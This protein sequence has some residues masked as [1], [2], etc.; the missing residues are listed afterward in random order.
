MNG[1]R[2]FI[3]GRLAPFFS[4]DPGQLNI[5]LP[6]ETEGGAATI[7]IDVDGVT[8]AAF[9]IKVDELAPAL[10]ILPE[11]IAGPGRAIAQNFP[12]FSLNTPLSP[13]PAGGIIIVYL[14][15]IGEVTNP[16]PTGQAAPL[17]VPLSE[18]TNPFRVRVRSFSPGS[19]WATVE[20][21]KSS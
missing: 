14:V 15:G 9:T 17:G 13:V 2:V 18:S 1:V 4:A 8:T 6:Y 12:D 3:N 21:S 19:T 11:I 5:Q 16:V 10:F 7:V 20:N